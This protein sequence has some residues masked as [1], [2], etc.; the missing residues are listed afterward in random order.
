MIF[1][2]FDPD[3]PEIRESPNLGAFLAN[4][5]PAPHSRTPFI[6]AERHGDTFIAFVSCWAGPLEQ[7]EAV[8]IET[9]VERKPRAAKAR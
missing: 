1:L 4:L 2:A 7:G 6:P 8:V 5:L 3:R 9:G